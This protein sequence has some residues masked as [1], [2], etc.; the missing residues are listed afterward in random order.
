MKSEA[1]RNRKFYMGVATILIAS[2]L[3]SCGVDQGQSMQHLAQATPVSS[4]CTNS[5]PVKDQ[6]AH[7]FEVVVSGNEMTIQG[8]AEADNKL[9]ALFVTEPDAKTPQNPSQGVEGMVYWAASLKDFPE[10][11]A[12][13]IRYGVAPAK[14]LDATKD[15][16]GPEVAV[17]LAQIPS[18]TC[19]KVTIIQFP[20][21]KTS[22][23]VVSR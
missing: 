3:Q 11:F 6:W 2:F 9:M 22:A 8:L 1:I 19:M 18:G 14:A 10:A 23:I 13:P 16:G 20:S 7:P 17:P 12:M 5:G 4:S 21:F 15:Y